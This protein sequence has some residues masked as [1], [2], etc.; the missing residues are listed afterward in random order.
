MQKWQICQDF[1]EVNKHTKVA[2]MPQGDIHVKQHRLSGHWY[3]SIIDFTL[4]FYA[5]EIDQELRPY[6][7]FY[8]EGLGH[9]WYIRMPFR[10][11]GAPTAFANITMTHLHDIIADEV[12]EVFVDDGGVASDTF[13]EMMDKLKQI[14]D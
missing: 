1:R 12:I 6:T 14:L 13:D 4:G 10:L 5:V 11:T 8:I 2:P 3:V 7:T 9:F